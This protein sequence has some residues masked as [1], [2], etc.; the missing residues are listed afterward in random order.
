MTPKVWSAL[1]AAVGSARAASHNDDERTWDQLQSDA[2]VDHITRP[3][4]G[5][6]GDRR[7]QLRRCRCSST[8]RRWCMATAATVA[9]TAD[10]E[11][12][13]G[14]GDPPVVL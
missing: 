7:G 5:D 1:N 12:V 13:A 11:V 4:S 10:G 14:G 6:N 3:H 8:T 9:E 2:I